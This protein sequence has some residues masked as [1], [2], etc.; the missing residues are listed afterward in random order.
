MVGKPMS[1]RKRRRLA[2]QAAARREREARAAAAAAA[3]QGLS[4]AAPPAPTAAAPTSN[5]RCAV[6]SA[7]VAPAATSA[8]TNMSLASAAPT[9]CLGRSFVDLSLDSPRSLHKSTNAQSQAHALSQRV[10]PP[11]RL[12]R[13]ENPEQ[14][15]SPSPPSLTRASVPVATLANIQNHPSRPMRVSNSLHGG[16]NNA[17]RVPVQAPPAA[18]ASRSSSSSRVPVQRQQATLPAAS[19]SRSVTPELQ[20]QQKA[21]QVQAQARARPKPRPRPLTVPPSAPVTTL[22]PRPEDKQF[23]DQLFMA[24]QTQAHP[25]AR[26]ANLPRPTGPVSVFSPFV[27]DPEAMLRRCVQLRMLPSLNAEQIDN[28]TYNVLK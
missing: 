5:E 11:P 6:T 7:A 13:I 22:A 9:N 24:C 8:S 18:A 28:S 27:H 15:S 26:Y 1:A 23:L 20:R 10:P 3:A 17:P 25:F 16:L 21:G 14:K 4:A 2:Q 19:I 12:G